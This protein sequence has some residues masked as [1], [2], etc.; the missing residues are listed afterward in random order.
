MYCDCC[1]PQVSSATGV[2]HERCQT[3]LDVARRCHRIEA[4]TVYIIH[5]SSI[6]TRHELSARE[7]ETISTS[8]S[9]QTSDTPRETLGIRSCQYDLQPFEMRTNE[10]R[11][12][13]V[14]NAIAFNFLCHSFT[15]RAGQYTAV[16]QRVKVSTYE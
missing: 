14:R 7:R 10:K 5:L 6:I 15:R 2:V 9:F 1:E 12:V 11:I 3:H 16:V 13:F 4:V 8:T